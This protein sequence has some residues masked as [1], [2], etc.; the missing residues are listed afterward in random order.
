MF[1][2][3]GKEEGKKKKKQKKVKSKKGGEKKTV[4]SLDIF[5]LFGEITFIIHRHSVSSRF[6]IFL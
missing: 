6:R 1:A 2:G 5:F 3:S 4:C